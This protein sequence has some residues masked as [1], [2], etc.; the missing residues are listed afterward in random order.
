MSFVSCQKGSDEGVMTGFVS[1]DIF[2][3]EII[4]MFDGTL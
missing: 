2:D 4:G 1:R 3:G